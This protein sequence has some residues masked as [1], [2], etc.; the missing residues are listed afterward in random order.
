MKIR[1][2]RKIA[3]NCCERKYTQKQIAD[4]L[5][6]IWHQSRTPSGKRVL[7]LLS[8]RAF[9]AV[10]IEFSNLWRVS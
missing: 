7:G 5:R 8:P 2:A 9:R 6:T 4:A 3:T 1:Q 10:V